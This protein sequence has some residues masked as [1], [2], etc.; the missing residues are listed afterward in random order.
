[1]KWLPFVACNFIP[2]GSKAFFLSSLSLLLPLVLPSLGVFSPAGSFRC[3]FLLVVFVSA[4][5]V[6]WVFFTWVY[7]LLFFSFSVF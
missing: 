7:L 2:M 6:A 5:Y 4:L 1:V 3:L